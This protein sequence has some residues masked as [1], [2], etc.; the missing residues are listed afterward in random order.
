MGQFTSS[1]AIFVLLD[2]L[3]E[4][5]LLTVK[6]LP[7]KSFVGLLCDF[8]VFQDLGEVPWVR[9]TKSPKI[10]K[11]IKQ[12]TNCTKSFSFHKRTDHKI[13]F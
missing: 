1:F 13:F 7:V 6:I 10:F 9:G 2:K 4:G 5:P 3:T 8:D 11:I 12:I